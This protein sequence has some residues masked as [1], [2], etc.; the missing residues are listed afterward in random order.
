[1]AGMTNAADLL[2]EARCRAKLSQAELARRSGIPRSVLSAYENGRRQPGADA[3][4]RILDAA[5]LDVR[6]TGKTPRAEDEYLAR[7]LGQVL[8]LAEALPFEREGPLAYPLFK[9]RAG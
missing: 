8:D 2:Y 3:L 7:I 9:R 4:F 1:M 6:L 5:G